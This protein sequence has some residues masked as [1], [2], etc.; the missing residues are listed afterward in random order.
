RV[1][2]EST[3]ASPIVGSIARN[4]STTCARSTVAGSPS[5][6]AVCACWDVAGELVRV[7]LTAR[8][9]GAT[10]PAGRRID[11]AVC[12]SL[13]DGVGAHPK[14]YRADVADRRNPRAVHMSVLFERHGISS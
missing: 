11:D 5:L 3:V 8:R 14:P 6:D 7:V 13:R 1:Q 10:R 4:R 2:I 12:D 9:S